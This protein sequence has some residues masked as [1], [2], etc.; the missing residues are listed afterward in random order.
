[1]IIVGG[2]SSNRFGSDKLLAEVEGQPLIAHTIDAVGSLVDKCVVVC[3]AEIVEAVEH[4]RP[5]I[6]VTT[7]GSSRTLSEMAGLAALGE[8]DLIAIHDAARPVVAGALVDVLFTTADEVGGAVPILEPDHLM[9]QRA[10]H[11]VRDGLRRAQTPQVFRGAE[12]MAAYVRAAQEGFEGHDTAEIVQRYSD[13]EVAGVQGDTDN[14][15][16]TFPSDLAVVA[17]SIR[18]RSRT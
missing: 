10:T 18:A 13:L 5:D 2:G 6:T 1:M 17:R 14:V 3:R 7:G 8:T 16:V 9:I 15:K 11:Q 4:L 12:L